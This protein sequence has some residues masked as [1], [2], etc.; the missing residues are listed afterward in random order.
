MP[1]ARRKISY[2]RELYVVRRKIARIMKGKG[3]GKRRAKRTYGVPIVDLSCCKYELLRIVLKNNGWEEAGAEETNSHLIWTDMSIGP[4]RLMTLKRG[5]KINHYFGMLQICRKKS[6]ARNLATMRKM[7]PSQYKFFPRSFILPNQLPELLSKFNFHKTRTY[8]LKPDNGCQGR[9]VAL[10]QSATDVR[11]AIEGLSGSNLL[12][13]K[14]LANPM[15]INGY[16]F[17]LRIYVLILSCDPLRFYLYREGIVRFC[18]EK[19]SK[20]DPGNLSLSC[21]HLTN[22]AVNKHNGKFEFNTKA[23][24]TD[25]GHKW[26]LTS[27]YSA[28]ATRGYDT[29]KLHRQISQLVVMT[30]IGIVPLLVHNYKAYLPDDDTG[31]TCFEVLGMDV[32]L[33]DKCK[34]WLLEVNHSPSFT[35]DTP[36]DLTV[37]ES[38]LMDTLRLVHMDPSTVSKLRMQERK[39]AMSRLYGKVTPGRENTGNHHSV[40]PATHRKKDPFDENEKTNRGMYD[41]IYPSE[42]KNLMELYRIFLAGSEAAFKHSFHMRVK[43]TIVRVQEERKQEEMAKEVEERKKQKA[44]TEIRKK[45]QNSARLAALATRERL[46]EKLTAKMA[47]DLESVVDTGQL[48]RP[49]TPVSQEYGRGP[50][51]RQERSDNRDKRGQGTSYLRGKISNSLVDVSRWKTENKTEIGKVVYDRQESQEEASTRTASTSRLDY[52]REEY[53]RKPL[54]EL[55]CRQIYSKVKLSQG[56][57]DLVKPPLKGVAKH[58]PPNFIKQVIHTETMSIKQRL[59]SLRKGGA[60]L[61]ANAISVNPSTFSQLGSKYFRGTKLQILH[62]EP[63]HSG[64]GELLPSFTDLIRGQSGLPRLLDYTKSKLTEQE[65]VSDSVTPERYAVGLSSATSLTPSLTL[66][67]RSYSGLRLGN[68]FSDKEKHNSSLFRDKKSYSWL[69][70]PM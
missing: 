20:P 54:N 32:L 66:L 7:F 44:R 35:I 14:Y 62:L 46:V 55:S 11:A 8:I 49:L 63:K 64:R 4:E 53:C 57:H 31:R 41:R 60:L 38:L 21:M 1:G 42:D 58:S 25:K 2:H 36:L 9:G 59:P 17:D 18:T 51:N 13:Q 39:C 22:Y 69:R 40:H 15:L 50:A 6:L 23:D 16:K 65:T 5:Q 24:E 26:T 10:A 56:R 52:N 47:E 28:L 27:L 48:D 3:G 61:K 45:A 67:A 19:Y 12:A 37:K 70:S 43:D 30:I 33:D 68:V 34:P 29:Q